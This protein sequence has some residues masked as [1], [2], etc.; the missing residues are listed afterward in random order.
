MYIHNNISFCR[1]ASFFG[2]S[3]PC[4]DSPEPALK[5]MKQKGQHMEFRERASSCRARSSSVEFN[6]LSCALLREV[7]LSSALRASELANRTFRN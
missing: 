3:H 1:V 5:V 2:F 7:G 4:Y 6:V